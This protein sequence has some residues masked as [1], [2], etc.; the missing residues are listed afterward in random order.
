MKKKSKE[1][2]A[3]MVEKNKPE[4]A[5]KNCLIVEAF[6]DEKNQACSF[7]NRIFVC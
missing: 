1:N 2:R 5:G 3:N 4:Q 6:K 7:F